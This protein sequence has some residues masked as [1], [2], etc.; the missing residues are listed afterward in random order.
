M[1]LLLQQENHVSTTAEFL[2][3]IDANQHFGGGES[4]L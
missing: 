4:S 1:S 3:T 2:I